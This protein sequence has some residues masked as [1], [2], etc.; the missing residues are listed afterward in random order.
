MDQRKHSISV[1]VNDAD[2]K[3]IRSISKRLRIKESELYRFAIKNMLGRLVP[4]H[5]DTLHGRDLLPALLECGEDLSK[6]F[7]LDT[8]I[9]DEIINGD[10]VTPEK[11][12]EKS[13]LDLFA[14]SNF[15]TGYVQLRLSEMGQEH[16]DGNAL[17]PDI[18]NYLRK[19]YLHQRTEERSE[20]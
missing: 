13:D 15:A 4:L 3:K 9:L 6:Y 1:R 16:L 11:R 18:D 19:K 20:T 8:A 10:T 2:L 5:D 14:M 17:W 7:D 12:I